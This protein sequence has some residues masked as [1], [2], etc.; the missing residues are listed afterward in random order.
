MAWYKCGGGTMTETQL[1]SNSAPT[2]NFS[3]GNRTLSQSVDDFK[4]IRVY[5]RLSK[6]N[7][8]TTYVTYDV[9]E[10]KKYVLAGTNLAAG[11]A[12]RSPSISYARTFYYV[13]NTTI[14]FGSCYKLSTTSSDDSLII[15][16]KVCG[17]K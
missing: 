4:K 2:S 6:S 13:D 7:S 5:C 17:L 11:V 10:F 12:Y 16:T 15:P 1:W 14:F 9:E 8:T 3:S